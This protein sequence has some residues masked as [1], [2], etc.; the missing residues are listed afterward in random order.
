MVRMPRATAGCVLVVMWLALLHSSIAAPTTVAGRRHVPFGFFG[1]SWDPTNSAASDQESQAALISRAGVEAVR[2]SFNWDQAQPYAS[3]GLVPQGQAGSFVVGPGGVPTSFSYTDRV[4]RAT[5]SHH[6]RLLPVVLFTPRWASSNP[7]TD[8]YYRYAPRDFATFTDY[9]TALV[10]RYGPGGTFWRDNPRV[11][12]VP[13]REWQIWN[14]EDDWQSWPSWRNQGLYVGLLEASYR[15]LHRLDPGVR[16]VLGGLANFPWQTSWQSL[17]R[18]Y[19]AGA[20][21][22]FDVAALHP[23]SATVAHVL[24]IIQLNRSVMARYGDG[25]KPVY[26]TE[27]AWSAPKVRVDPLV[28]VQVSARQQGRLLAAAYS[29]LRRHRELRVEQADWFKWSGDYR[30]RSI[31]NYTGLVAAYQHAPH[32]RPLPLL[33]AYAG[34]ARRLEGCTKSDLA[35]RCKPARRPSRHPR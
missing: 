4:V 19:Q 25:R 1:V 8:E 22:F 13:V 11:L 34:I 9:L 2:T 3:A 26:V 23:Y 10:H 31:W 6:L 27:L 16:V 28:G 20:R 17:E 24:R 35:S 33:A 32:F 12:R 5:A 21:G 29:A 18:L 15:T 30:G 7:A 14:E